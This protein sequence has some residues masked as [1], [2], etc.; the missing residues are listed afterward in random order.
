MLA[1]ACGLNLLGARQPA[2]SVTTVGRLGAQIGL[3]RGYCSACVCFVTRRVTGPYCTAPGCQRYVRGPPC[4]IVRRRPKW[5]PG[6][7]SPKKCARQSDSRNFEKCATI[8]LTKVALARTVDPT[9]LVSGRSTAAAA[10]GLEAMP[11]I[12]S[13]ADAG[14]GMSFSVVGCSAPRRLVQAGSTLPM[15]SLL[16]GR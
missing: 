14:A 7:A 3:T 12:S 2:L 1:A 9:R 15:A 4:A 10:A 5:T 8:G 11:G 13:Q 16:R 6:G